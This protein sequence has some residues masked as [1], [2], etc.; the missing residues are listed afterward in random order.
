M[1]IVEL[2]I[3]LVAVLYAGYA[4]FRNKANNAAKDAVLGETRGQDKELK[5][6]EEKI[7][8]AIE[9]VISSDDSNLTPEERAKRWEN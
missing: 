3:G 5:A 7:I 2:L 4:Y 9:D 8:K 1:G 6:A